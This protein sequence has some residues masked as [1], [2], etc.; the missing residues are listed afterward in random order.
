M[1]KR[2]E[3]INKCILEYLINKKYNNSIEPF[4][5]DTGIQRNDASTGNKLEKKWSTLLSLQKK[6]SDLENEVKQ[7]KEDLE[8]GGGG[9]V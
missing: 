4:I 6:I 9:T 2:E 7:L 5:K 8:R 3:K 1:K